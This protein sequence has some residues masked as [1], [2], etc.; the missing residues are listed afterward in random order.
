MA[1]EGR[2]PSTRTSGLTPRKE[3]LFLRELPRTP[4]RSQIKGCKIS[5]S[6]SVVISGSSVSPAF[7][8]MRVSAKNWNDSRS[9]GINWFSLFIG[10]QKQ[11]FSFYL[12]ND[13]LC[14]YS[15]CL[16]PGIYCSWTSALARSVHI[17]ARMW[18]PV[19][20][21]S[22]FPSVRLQGCLGGRATTSHGR[23]LVRV[24]CLFCL[25]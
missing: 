3:L 12:T 7:T 5:Q 14:I 17:R 13:L 24:S 22:R 16:S 21:I 8:H 6:S 19:S 15:G 20:S 18:L 1:Q 23:L 11:M 2:Y 4:R 9:L 10:N 25:K